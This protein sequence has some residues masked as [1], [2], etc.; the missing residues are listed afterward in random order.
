[1]NA[2]ATLLFVIIS[3][4][5]YACSVVAWCTV[6]TS[7]AGW[8]GA[9]ARCLRAL[10][11]LSYCPP[12]PKQDLFLI[13]F[14]LVHILTCPPCALGLAPTLLPTD[15]ILMLPPGRSMDLI[16]VLKLYVDSFMLWQ[17]IQTR[18]SFFVADTDH[19]L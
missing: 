17:V 6:Q 14:P 12:P 4:K 3:L 8:Q 9:G 15:E 13:M 10:A 7:W 11:L 19:S 1:M 5:D 18:L 16:R 2:L